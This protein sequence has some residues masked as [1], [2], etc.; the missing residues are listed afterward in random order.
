M[1][2]VSLFDAKTHL[3]GI[4]ESLVEG[5]EDEVI[6]ARR[7]KP[8]AR[9]TSLRQANVSRRIG[10]ARGRLTVPDD[11]DGSNAVVAR[12]LAGRAREKRP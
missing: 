10:A 2:T 3:S 4:V 1:H 7:G 5:R 6:I 11:I 9:L 12:L 8:V